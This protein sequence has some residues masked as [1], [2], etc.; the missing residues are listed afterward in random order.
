MISDIIISL[1]DKISERIPCFTQLPLTDIGYPFCVISE[2]ISQTRPRLKGNIIVDLWESNLN[3]TY[4]NI[5]NLAK[6]L[7]DFALL[8]STFWVF[9][10]WEVIQNVPTSEEGLT[11]K[12]IR[13]EINGFYG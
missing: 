5:D 11:R 2:T 8:H 7:Y 10:K 6:D 12:Q 13:L 4:I 9:G 1:V 3:D